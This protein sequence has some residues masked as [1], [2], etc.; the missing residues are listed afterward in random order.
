[1][2]RAG[3]LQCKLKDVGGKK[4]TSKKSGEAPDLV[5]VLQTI[6]IFTV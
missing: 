1:M 2:A 6:E 5:L 4:E 3:K